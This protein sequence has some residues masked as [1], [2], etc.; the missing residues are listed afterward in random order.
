MATTKKEFSATDA[1]PIVLYALTDPTSQNAI[2]VLVDSSGRIKVVP[3]PQNPLYITNTT[4]FEQV[5]DTLTLYVN[6]V[7]RQTWTTSSG[8]ITI[9]AGNPVGLL[10]SLTYS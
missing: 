3:G 5:G 4:Y 9:V 7:A 6:S 10:L 1:R 8:S 2:P